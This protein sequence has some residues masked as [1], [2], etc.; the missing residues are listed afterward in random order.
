MKA[1]IGFPRSPLLTAG[2]G[3]RSNGLSDHQIK[4]LVAPSESLDAPAPPAAEPQTSP[5]SN[6]MHQVLRS[7]APAAHLAQ[8]FRCIA[9]DLT[10]QP[11][12]TPFPLRAFLS[13]P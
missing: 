7:P 3:G 12:P 6:A 9:T 10:A 1:S 4:A 5:H 8:N 13:I 11:A 2:A